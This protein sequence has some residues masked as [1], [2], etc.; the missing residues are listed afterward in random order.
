[1]TDGFK[2]GDAVQLSNFVN[3]ANNNCVVWL[4]VVSALSVTY[5]SDELVN[6]TGPATTTMVRP[7]YIE[8]GANDI[9]FWI[10]KESTDL[11]NK[12]NT[13]RDRVATM[14]L[15]FKY[16][17]FAMVKFGMAGTFYDPNPTTLITASRTIDP[18]T[19]E[20]ALNASSDLGTI[21][22]DGVLADYCIETLS[23]QTNLTMQAVNSCGKLAPLDQ[24]PTGLTVDVSM[25]IYLTDSNFALHKSKLSQTPIN[26]QYW[27]RDDVSGGGYAVRI[28]RVH[29][30]FPDFATSGKGQVAKLSAKGSASYDA[31]SNN[32][33]RIYKLV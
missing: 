8:Y 17:D 7:N 20:A 19:A 9:W 1:M 2:V 25:D 24:R 28:P 26:I 16:G 18:I 30:S 12:G 31:V 14:S 27:A 13:Y 4:S 3:A 23:L 32:T 15:D 29:L 22:I 5:I 21:V 11:T 6:E 10:S 33:L